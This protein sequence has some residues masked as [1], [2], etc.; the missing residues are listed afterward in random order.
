[1][2]YVALMPKG[3]ILKRRLDVPADDSS[4]PADLLAG[5]GVALVRHGRAALLTAREIF[6]GLADFGALQVADFE[7]DL[8]A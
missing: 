3:N 8:F 5:D 7:R 6:F 4:Q 2:R 1:M